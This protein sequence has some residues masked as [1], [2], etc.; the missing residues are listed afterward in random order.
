MWMEF[1]E[2]RGTPGL[3]PGTWKLLVTTRTDILPQRSDV[4]T[5]FRGLACCC[6]DD[7]DNNNKIINIIILLLACWTLCFIQTHNT[8]QKRLAATKMAVC[9]YSDKSSFC[10][11]LSC[12]PNSVNSFYWNLIAEI[13]QNGS[14][15]TVIYV[16][17]PRFECSRQSGVHSWQV[18]S[19]RN[20]LADTSSLFCHQSIYI[21]G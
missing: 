9:F 20:R 7:D 4:S 14:T 10:R 11:K 5:A 2:L 16:A 13:M 12:S 21:D 8:T 18:F 1:T 3:P 6:G 15:A 17:R 19:D